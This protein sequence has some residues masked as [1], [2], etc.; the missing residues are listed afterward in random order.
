MRLTNVNRE[1]E[2]KM[3]NPNRYGSITKLSGPRRKPYWVREGRTGKQK[4]IGYAATREEAIRLLCDY[5]LEPWNPEGRA[6]TLQQLWEGF[7]QFKGSIYSEGQQN[8][9]RTA[10]NY[11]APW[12][13]VPYGEIR[14]A[15][16]Q[17]LID[18]MEKSPAIKGSVKVLI[19]HLD[20]YAA[21]LNIMTRPKAQFLTVR[22]GDYQPKEKKVFTEEEVL[23]FWSQN[24]IFSKQ[25][26]V[27]LYTGFRITEATNLRVSD[28][29][30]NERT[31]KGGIKSEAGRNRLVPVHPRIQPIIDYMLENSST[32]YLFESYGKRVS[33]QK[34]AKL[35]KA[36]GHTPHECRHTFRTWLDNVNANKVCID[37]IMGHVSES[38][39]ER[40]YTHKTISDLRAAIELLK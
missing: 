34:F 29:D 35:L 21:E 30:P 33:S 9:M 31:L 20:K 14:V 4:T 3:K 28:Y 38:V 27:L 7:R 17:N 11:L 1:S 36:F 16:L 26:I 25:V 19:G 39:G 10:Y 24:D 12:Y 22:A 37:R 18:N 8:N 5:N 40:V 2:E 6:V 13:E 32:G 23:K 15:E